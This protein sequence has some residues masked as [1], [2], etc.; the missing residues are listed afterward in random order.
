MGRT[1]GIEV[2]HARSCAS[3]SGARCNCGPSY[4]A[5]VWSS[6]DRTRIRKTFPTLAAAKSWRAEA[7]VALN[8]GEM[9]APS[10]VSLRD[11]G[12][13]WL[14]GARDGTIRNRSGDAYKPSVIRS[15]EASFRRR[16]LPDLGAMR[17]ADIRRSDVQDLADRLLAEGLDPSSIRNALMPLR[18]IFRRAVG[19]GEIAVNPCDRIQ[20]PAVRGRRERI[21]SPDEAARLV[22]AVPDR[23]RA[24]W[25]TAL[26]G[27][28]RRGELMALLWTD[29][30]LGTGLIRVERSWDPKE[31]VTV[32]TKS[33]G[34]R[35][36]VPMA[37]ALRRHLLE[38]RLLTGSGEG[39]VFGRSPV[40]PFDYSSTRA[41]AIKAWRAAGIQP[42]GL[43]ECR[44]TFASLM[45]AAGVNAKALSTYMGHASITITLDRYGH[46]MPGNEGEAAG[47]LDALLTRSEAAAEIP[48]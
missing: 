22:A 30:D 46:L 34:G 9:R 16:L 31:R 35:R 48:S 3:R 4:Q 8:R 47:L 20:L 39:L 13:A 12:E 17:L 24:M 27:G 11:A 18:V 37:G 40:L 14:V 19:R 25:A 41:R 1:T 23:D 15:Y 5:N 21:A 6:R 38:H 44:H 7:T 29:V 33:R 2:R 45:I 10:A 36:R 26:Y 28:L 32:A 42:I 43:H